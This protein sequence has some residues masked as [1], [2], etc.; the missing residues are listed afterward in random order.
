M[1]TPNWKKKLADDAFH[2]DHR[3]ERSPE[4]RSKRPMA[5]EV[6][7]RAPTNAAW[8]AGGAF[9]PGSVRYFPAP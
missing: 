2:E 7:S 3:Q 4:S 5:A 9:L 1:V 6:I 8:D